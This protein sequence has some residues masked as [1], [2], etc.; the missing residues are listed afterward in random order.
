M[1][2]IGQVKRF[3]EAHINNE[4]YTHY[5]RG[6]KEYFQEITQK[7]YRYHYHILDWFDK[8]ATGNRKSLLE[9]GCGIGIDTVA[10]AQ[11]DFEITAI[12]LT[13]AAIEVAR[14]RID[15][16]GL[17]I[18]YRVGNCE[19]LEFEDHSFDL[20]YSFGVIHHTPDIRRAVNEIHRVLKPGGRAY[21][22]IYARYSLVNAIHCLFRLPFESPKNLKDECPVVIRSSARQARRLFG[23]FSSVAV[24]KDYPFTYGLRFLSHW[25]PVSIQ[26]LLGRGIGWHLMIEARK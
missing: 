1:K 22:M 4:Y 23:A 7:R 8:M 19:Q 12:D 16:L 24:H 21:I 11:R 3:W 10:L 26:R 25:I 13:S 9:I 5:T 17:Q 2:A 6:S 20:V 18:D 14:R 15:R